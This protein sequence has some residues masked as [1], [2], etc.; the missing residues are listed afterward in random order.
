MGAVQ[1]SICSSS[2]SGVLLVNLSRSSCCAATEAAVLIFRIWVSVL[3]SLLQEFPPVD[4]CSGGAVTHFSGP[5]MSRLPISIPRSTELY[6]AP[7]LAKV[8][9]RSECSPFLVL[10]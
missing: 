2:R 4:F 9:V 3:N 6:A 8:I 10:L 1:F 5:S 7:V